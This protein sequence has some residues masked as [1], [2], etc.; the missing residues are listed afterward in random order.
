METLKGK[1]VLFIT[2]K[3]ID[4]LRN[5]QEIALLEKTAA[6]VTVLGFADK[7]YVKRLLKLYIQLLFMPMTAFDGVFI[8]FAPQLILPFFSFKFRK[9]SVCMDFF[10]SVY[11]TMVFDRRKFREGGIAARL[12]K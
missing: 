5:V 2:T 1:R 6:C 3:N 4:Y 9:C 11:D 7:S 8:G 10:I 12:C